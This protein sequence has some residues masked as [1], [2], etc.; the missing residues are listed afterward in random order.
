M[1][2]YKFHFD[3]GFHNTIKDTYQHKSHYYDKRPSD[4]D[5]KHEEYEIYDYMT[6]KTG[7]STFGNRFV[8]GYMESKKWRLFP[9]LELIVKY[10]HIIFQ[11]G[12]VLK[13][14]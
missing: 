2:P 10:S 8:D 6:Y 13:Y 12:V 11:D 4:V 14:Y 9:T 3:F 7:A 1:I 5:Y